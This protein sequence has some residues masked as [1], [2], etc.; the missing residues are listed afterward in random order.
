MKNKLLQQ[1]PSGPNG[2]KADAAVRQANA[3][4]AHIWGNTLL[5]CA[6]DTQAAMRVPLY[7]KMQ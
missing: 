1:I 5:A 3:K 2:L 4:T 7:R 6:K